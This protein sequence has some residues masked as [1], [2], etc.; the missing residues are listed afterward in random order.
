MEHL[1]NCGPWNSGGLEFLVGAGIGHDQEVAGQNGKW[2]RRCFQVILAHNLHDKLHGT[3]ECLVEVTLRNIEQHAQWRRSWAITTWKRSLG[4]ASYY[5]AASWSPLVQDPTVYDEV[6]HEGKE[7]ETPWYTF[8]FFFFFS[9]LWNYFIQWHFS[10]TKETDHSRRE[11]RREMGKARY[12]KIIIVSNY[13]QR[14]AFTSNVDYFTQQRSRLPKAWQVLP[15]L[16]MLSYCLNFS[17]HF[18][19]INIPPASLLC[20]FQLDQLTHTNWHIS[21][22][23]KVF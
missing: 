14:A 21:K 22:L 6:G 19:Y 18:G 11:N 15:Y 8:T 12:I 16:E 7:F 4:C 3:P 9:L 1:S 23:F 2:P 10:W 5:P 13:P 20:T 17:P